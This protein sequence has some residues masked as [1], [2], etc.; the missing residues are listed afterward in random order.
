MLF[1]ELMNLGLPL[2]L[3]NSV[4]PGTCCIANT[5]VVLQDAKEFLNKYEF[6]INTGS[7]NEEHFCLQL[8]MLCH[9]LQ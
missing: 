4:C 8:L 6:V 3:N 9:V 5:S 2:L 7:S 1:L